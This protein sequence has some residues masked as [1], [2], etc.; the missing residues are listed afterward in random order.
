MAGAFRPR[1]RQDQNFTSIVA[2]RSWA[3]FKGTK[4]WAFWG[5]ARSEVFTG[6]PTQLLLPVYRKS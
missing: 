4:I 1:L 6:A 5:F 2:Y 3:F